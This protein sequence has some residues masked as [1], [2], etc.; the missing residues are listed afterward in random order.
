MLA[1]LAIINLAVAG[2][3]ISDTADAHAEQEP[4]AIVATVE[5]QTQDAEYI[6][7]TAE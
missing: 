1:T 3:M 5:A 4:V 6:S 7:W 2:V